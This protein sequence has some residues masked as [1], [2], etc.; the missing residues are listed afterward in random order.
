MASPSRVGRRRS[1]RGD[2][3]GTSSARRWRR[4]FW[5]RASTCMRAA[6]T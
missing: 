4:R 2:R 3:D 6:K 5:A 1:A